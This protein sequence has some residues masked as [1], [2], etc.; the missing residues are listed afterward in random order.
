MWPR[1]YTCTCTSTCTCVGIQRRAPP[2]KT[3]KECGLTSIRVHVRVCTR[4]THTHAHRHTHA[5]AHDAQA[6]ARTRT[7]THSSLKERVRAQ[8]PRRA[9][10]NIPTCRLGSRRG[11]AQYQAT[12][13]I[14]RSAAGAQ[15]RSVSKQSGVLSVKSNHGQDLAGAGARVGVAS[16]RCIDLTKDQRPKTIW[17]SPEIFGHVPNH[18]SSV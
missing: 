3:S 18:K 2:N 5:H 15:R 12:Q 6:H 1:I 17:S 9:S 14:K 4:T 16:A 8:Q 13:N 7:H 10:Q 11:G